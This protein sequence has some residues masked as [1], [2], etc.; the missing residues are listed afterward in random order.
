MLSHAIA[1]AFHR[2]AFK[3]R[4]EVVAVALKAVEVLR[5]YKPKKGHHSKK[6]S[7][8]RTP[9]FG[10]SLTP[11][12]EKEKF[13]FGSRPNSVAGS[14][15]LEQEDGS[16]ADV[17]DLQ[18]SKKKGKRKSGVQFPAPSSDESSPSHQYPPTPHTLETTPDRNDAN[19]PLHTREESDDAAAMVTKTAKVLKSAMFHDA[20]NIKGT[21]EGDNGLVWDV[22][23]SQEAKRLARSIFNTFHD[24]RRRYLIPSD[25]EPAFPTKE[26]AEAGFRVFDKDNNGDITR[27]EIKS[28]L[29]KVYKER[30]FLSRSMRDVSAALRT[31]D[32]IL[33]AVAFIILFFISITVFG[34]SVGDSLTSVCK[35]KYNS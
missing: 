27:Q 30:R 6:S 9:L 7:G 25:F 14:I 3:E 29:L 22:G 4:L 34:V 15:D 13:N 21:D 11:F 8:M 26:D 10:F 12:S 5:E 24:R 33:L 2:T 16:Q 18:S 17:E 20:R 32:H 28:T 31:L 19:T 1:F 35:Y 23:S